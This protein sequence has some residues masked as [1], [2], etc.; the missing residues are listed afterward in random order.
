M[1]LE[2]IAFAL[3]KGISLLLAP[4]GIILVFLFLG[5]FIW[6]LKRRRILARSLF[7]LAF[8][9]YG[10]SGTAPVANLLVWGL[11]EPARQAAADIA[12]DPEI[13]TVVV[14]SGGRAHDEG[15]A[16][17]DLLNEATRLR[18][19]KALDVCR[20]HGGIETLI[21]AGG[22][23]R[24]FGDCTAS[25]AETALVWLRHLGFPASIAVKLEEQSRDTRGNMDHIAPMVG[26]EPFYLVTSAVHVARAM[27]AAHSRG[28]HPIPVPC[29]FKGTEIRWNPW[30]L[31]PRPVNL[32]KTDRACHEYLGLAWQWLVDSSSFLRDRV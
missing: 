7:F 2:T 1:T 25:E 31:W 29:D 30:D 5:F 23:R 10:L 16:S 20:E 26:E 22:C 32:L 9:I 24:P 15:G 19:L 8:L 11:E 4:S 14:L 17:V 28:L 18:L 3:K 27:R 12:W 6:P 13:K 21:I